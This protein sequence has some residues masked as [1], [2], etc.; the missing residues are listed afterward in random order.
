MALAARQVL[1]ERDDVLGTLAAA[2]AAAEGGDGRLVFVA[3]ESGG[4]KSAVVHA[5]T[6]QVACPVRR[7]ACDPLSTPV[8]LA[9]FVDL[10]AR[11]HGALRAALTVVPC[12]AHAVFTALREDLADEPCVLVIEDAHWA[13]EATLDVLRILGRRI[14]TM[15]LLVIVTHRGERES[16]GDALRVALGDLAGAA[17]VV[18]LTLPPLSLEAVRLLADGHAVDA[19]ELHRRT[20]GN[21]FYVT[22]ALDAGDGTVPETVRDAVLAR[23]ARLEPGAREVLDLLACSPQPLGPA[24]IAAACGPS[25]TEVEAGIAAGLLAGDGTAV[26]FRHEIAREAI[27]GEL[28]ATRLAELHGAL[29]AAL[30]ETADA[31]PAR[32]AHHAEMAGDGDAAARYA[33]I[34]AGRAVAAGAYRQAAGQ[35]S[36]AL[37]QP[38]GAGGT[39]RADL[40]EQRAAA[41]FAADEQLRSIADLHAAI[42]LHRAS[43]DVGRETQA[44]ARLVPC[45]TCRGRLEEA[46]AAAQTAAALVGDVPRD[47]AAAYGALAQVYLCLDR[48]TDCVAAGE[49]SIVAA[50]AAGDALA[51]VHAGVSVGLAE[52]LRDGSGATDRMERVLERIR[53]ERLDEELPRALNDLAL[54]AVL[55]RDH[56]AAAHWIAE[57]IT[58]VE[59]HDLDLWR[60]SFVSLRLRSELDQ[61]RWNDATATAAEL[62]ADERDSPGP[63][64]E[65]LS[66]LTLIRARRGDPAPVGA[67]DDAGA[68]FDDPGWEIELACIH[69]EVAWLDGRAGDIGALTD[70]AVE[71]AAGR[72]SAWPFA[73]LLLWRHRAGLA[74]DL[75][76]PPLP[77][78]VAL[79]LAGRHAEAAAAWEE[80]GS[81]YEA[82]VALLLADDP[83]AI[84][85][86][87]AR[88][89]ALGAAPAAKLAAR[90]LRERGVRG[91][92][93]GPRPSTK[94]NAA[95]LTAR[96]QSVLDLVAEGL[97]N[98]QVAERLFLSPRTVDYHVSAVLR[99][100]DA[101]SRGEAVA[102]ALRL[103]LVEPR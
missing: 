79:E 55:A 56:A 50:D 101:K 85:D 48:L 69:A 2:L 80:L 37:R 19:A 38:E 52:A 60:L 83:A 65:A 9:P 43:G 100:L 13:D 49:Q 6:E 74:T 76:G 5:F 11:E 30:R 34:A 17:G 84:T 92:A 41:F 15:P 54:A 12:T 24:M 18:R 31:D 21:A 68:L 91:I 95:Q 93:R 63:R 35:Y 20:D 36:R 66:A 94:R 82:A 67:L 8:P 61:G 44:I 27:A 46:L 39:A 78:P 42:D 4:G 58:H 62:L 99:K 98:A 29:L 75:T 70:A 77:A 1:L 47:A 7:G 33:T 14:T 22:E 32:L 97:T 72:E 53:A 71:L 90:R 64:S 25:A 96:E 3:A 26:A 57:G 87:H 40:L 88:L 51:A 73:Q 45:L 86:A 59:G 103:G 10:A 81:P 102:T 28:Q 23:A 16:P 89:R